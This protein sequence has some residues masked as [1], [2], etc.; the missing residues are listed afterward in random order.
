MFTNLTRPNLFK[1]TDLL[2]D[3]NCIVYWVPF[4]AVSSIHFREVGLLENS[5]SSFEMKGRTFS[6]EGLA[7]LLSSELPTMKNGNA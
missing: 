2:V 3:L 1:V 6:Y 4:W 5:W 7:F